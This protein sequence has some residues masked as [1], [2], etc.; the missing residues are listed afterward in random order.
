MADK[1]GV[2]NG[3]LQRVGVLEFVDERHAPFGSQGLGKRFGLLGMFGVGQGSMHVEQQIIIVAARAAA[4]VF[5]Q[6]GF[7][8]A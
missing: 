4:F 7:Q 1:G 3:V 6:T 8:V 2:E 5:G